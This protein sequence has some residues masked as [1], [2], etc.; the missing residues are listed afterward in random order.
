MGRSVPMCDP[1]AIFRESEADVATGL[2]EREGEVGSLEGVEGISWNADS[3]SS[4]LGLCG[5]V[6]ETCGGSLN[7][8]RRGEV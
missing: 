1:F 6:C 5:S 4:D 3:F 2:G 7:A 8:T